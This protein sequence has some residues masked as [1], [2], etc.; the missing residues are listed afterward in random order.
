V[1]RAKSGKVPVNEGEQTNVENIYAIGDICEGKLELT[2]VAIEAGQLLAK[3]L[4]AGS[5]VLTDYVNVPT[6]VFTPIEY[7][8]CGY[9]EEAAL[10]KFGEENLEI[11][12]KQFTPLEWTVPH[13]PENTGYAKLLTL[14]NENERV[15]GFHYLGPNAG[16]VTQMVGLALKMKATKADFDALIGIHPTCAEIFT[17]LTITKRSGESAAGT[18]C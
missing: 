17:T 6:T 4:Y 8:S 2:P 14:T 1:K 16:E 10:K 18:G 3:R 5:K 11:Y 9:S 13:R 12:I 7:G 15:V